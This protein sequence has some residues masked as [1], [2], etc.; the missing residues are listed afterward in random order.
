LIDFFSFIAHTKVA[1]L[2][3]SGEP[4]HPSPLAFAEG[5]FCLLKFFLE[6]EGFLK[7]L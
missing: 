3:L 7:V 5:L 2:V 4:D 1:K 6:K